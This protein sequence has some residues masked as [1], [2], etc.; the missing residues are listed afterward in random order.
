MRRY[1]FPRM[2]DQSAWVG[3]RG[4]YRHSKY[5]HN[6]GPPQ[7]RDPRCAIMDA[8]GVPWVKRMLARVIGRR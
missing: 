7:A 5:A 1:A 8:V 2:M 3:F 4:G 6:L